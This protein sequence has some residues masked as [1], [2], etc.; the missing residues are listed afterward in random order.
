VFLSNQLNLVRLKIFLPVLF[1]LANAYAYAG[2][3]YISEASGNDKNPG[4]QL[5]PW[6][7][8]AKVSSSAF[9]PGDSILFKRGEV[10]YGKLTINNNGAPGN[11]IYI[12]AYGKGANPLITGFTTISEWKKSGPNIWESN[13]EVSSL[14]T[15]NLVVING[16]NIPM[17]R[18]PNS[19]YLTFQSHND[20]TSITSSSLTGSVNWTGADVIIRTA[21]YL[22][23][24]GDITSQSSGTLNYS[25]GYSE[26][27]DNWGFFIQNDVKTL[28]TQ[29]EWYY[30]PST[31]K[32]KIYSAA[33]PKNVKIASIDNL[34]SDYNKDYIK[35]ENLALEG[36]NSSAIIFTSANHITITNCNLSFCGVDGIRADGTSSYIDLEHNRVHDCNNAAISFY[37]LTQSNFIIKYNTVKRTG[38]STNAIQSNSNSYGAINCPGNNSLIQYNTVDSSGYTGI[39]FRGANSEVRNNFV[40]NS[41]LIKDDGAGIYTS[42][43]ETGKIIEGN[44]VL[45]SKGNASG[46]PSKDL[47][48]NGIYVDDL[49]TYVTVSNN[50][51]AN[52]NS[53]GLLLHSTNNIT[54]TG[55]TIYN[56]KG[57]GFMR[58]A[59]MIQGDVEGAVRN[60]HIKNNIFFAK[61]AT[62]YPFFYYNTISIDDAKS[63]G[64]SDNNYYIRPSTDNVLFRVLQSTTNYYNMA[65][66]QKFAKGQDAHSVENTTK[67]SSSDEIRFEYNA[68]LQK[69]KI[70]LDGKYRDIKN[71]FYDHSITLAPYGSAVL[72]REH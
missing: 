19:G 47:M 68:S 58:G 30:N 18:Y 9:K 17:G 43:K 39:Q 63:Y 36:A 54:I 27:K 1:L 31:N 42:G 49:G 28:D 57:L 26:P 21:H 32:I 44:I 35:V 69:K 67:I 60:N 8:I 6:R 24:K 70:S 45:N 41:C 33:L 22:I 38:L 56:S 29:N 14:A 10:F 13:S 5:L 52:C 11:L 2:N 12:G 16:N 72:I 53:A 55:N 25:G 48:A 64:V 51:I 20:K 7:T 62:Q 40:T 71:S 4:T 59:L 15:L 3:K 34:I 23:A 46:T 65:D 66:W 61:D 37:G 50:S